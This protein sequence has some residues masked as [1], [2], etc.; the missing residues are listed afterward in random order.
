MNQFYEIKGI[1]REFSIVRTPQHKGEAER[2]NRTQIEAARTMFLD[3]KLPNHLGLN[4]LKLLAMRLIWKSKLMVLHEPKIHCCSQARKEKDPEQEYILITLCTTDPLISQGPK[5]SKGDAGMKPTEVDE[6]GASDKNAQD[7]RSESERLNQREMQTEHT[8]S[9]NNINTV[10]TAGPSFDNAD[11]S[12][13]VNTAGPSVSTAN[14]FDEHLF[15]HFSPFKNAFTLPPV[16]NVT[17]QMRYNTGI[18]KM[19]N[20]YEDL[21]K[22]VDKNNVLSSIQSLILPF[23][24]FHKDHLKSS[25]RKLVAQG[26]TQ[27]EG[28]DYDEVFAPVA[29]IEAIRLFMAYA[30]FKDFVVFQ[31]DVK[32]AF[33]YGKIEE[34]VSTEEYGDSPFDLEAFSDSDYAGASLDMKS[35]TRAT[36]AKYVAAANYYGQNPVFHSKTKHIEIRHHFIRDSYEKKLIQV[37]KIHTDQN[38][39]DL[40]TKAFDASKKPTIYTSL[41]QLFWETASASTSENEEIEITATIDRRFK[42][43][44]EASIR[45]HLKLEDSNGIPTLPNAKFFEQLA[46]MGYASDSDKLTFQKGHFS[47]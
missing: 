32:S 9:T 4:P 2:K 25:D 8:N 28:I 20:D 37:I 34:E 29:R 35:T 13:S 41:I 43:I 45:R 18:F 7:T 17:V 11:P 12:P 24:P 14:A 5:D 39:A 40:L 36:E 16:P 10:S 15:E 38:V 19:L 44:T 6:R 3:S 30:S 27:E 26:H 33:L 46:L 47:P 1:K 23:H 42:T 22:E 31:M 21:E